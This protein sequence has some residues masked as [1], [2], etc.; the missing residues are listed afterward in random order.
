MRYDTDV[1]IVGG[2]PAGLAAG[3]AARAR[4]F[5]V[6][7]ADG[8]A[9][10]IT[11]ACGEGLLPDAIQALDDLGVRLRKSDGFTLRGIRFEDSNASVR[12][13]FPVGVGKGLRREVL[14]ERILERARDCGVSFLWNAP[15]TGLD[16]DGVIAGGKKICARWVIGADGSRSRVRRWAGLESHGRVVVRSAFRQH[17]RATPWSEVAEIHWVDRTQAYVTP[18]AHDE[19]CVA[20]ISNKPDLRVRDALQSFPRLTARLKNAPAVSKERGALTGMFRFRSVYRENVA[21]IGDASGGV[22]AVTGEGLCLGFRQAIALADA[23][24]AGNLGHYQQAHRR[25]F[26]RPRYIG[27][28]LLLMDRRSFVRKRTLRAME[29]APHL[30][31]G[32][33]AYH[34]GA[35][36]F[37]QLA[38]TGTL[39]GWRFLTA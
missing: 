3:I 29:A 5:R 26:H 21:L 7:V 25:L 6:T 16:R 28:L 4:G 24:A 9:P 39:L 33:L 31:Q 2:G 18:V 11:K 12:A 20:I 37:P 17:F 22:D 35:M 13:D 10:P 14:H 27:N 1:F 19:I 8:N 15:I 23:L 38:I 36:R 34:V 30:F 32:M